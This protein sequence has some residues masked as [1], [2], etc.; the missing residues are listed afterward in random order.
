VLQHNAAHLLRWLLPCSQHFLIQI[1]P[2]TLCSFFLS[3]LANTLLNHWTKH[4]VSTRLLITVA[5]PV[6]VCLFVCCYKPR[7]SLLRLPPLQVKPLGVYSFGP[8]RRSSSCGLWFLVRSLKD[9]RFILQ[10]VLIAPFFVW[11]FCSYQCL[12]VRIP[13]LLYVRG[14][15]RIFIEP[16]LLNLPA[17]L[18]LS[19]VNM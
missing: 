11:G 10:A 2:L 8:P 18:V 7:R 13:D 19:P 6:V 3:W 17:L 4:V 5:L 15:F 14:V 9:V 16:K 12:L 1:S